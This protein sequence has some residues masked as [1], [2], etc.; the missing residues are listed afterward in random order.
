MG[1]GSPVWFPPRATLESSQCQRG[2]VWGAPGGITRERREH[3]GGLPNGCQ[4]R[5]ANQW[6]GW[7]DIVKVSPGLAPSR[8]CLNGWMGR[9]GVWAG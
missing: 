3:F 8:G 7:R 1:L 6:L 5:H 2:I 4:M 9:E